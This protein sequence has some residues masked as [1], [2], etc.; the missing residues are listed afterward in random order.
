LVTSVAAGPTL[1]RVPYAGRGL[2]RL[3]TSVTVVSGPT[4]PENR[5]I[6]TISQDEAADRR[7]LSVGT[8]SRSAVASVEDMQP[9]GGLLLAN[10][11][12]PAGGLLRGS[13]AWRLPANALASRSNHTPTCCATLAVTLWRTPATIPAPCRTTSGIETSSTRCDIPSCHRLVLIGI[14]QPPM[15]ALQSTSGSG[16][17]SRCNRKV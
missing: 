13:P 11:H 10:W 9:I 5:P 2:L 1:D 4:R 14:R 15:S 12:L 6:G 3:V 17:T 16:R 8:T 7:N